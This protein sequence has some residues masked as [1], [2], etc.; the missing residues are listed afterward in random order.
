MYLAS[1]TLHVLGTIFWLGGMFFEL[2]A[3]S[4]EHLRVRTL[5]GRLG[6]LNAVW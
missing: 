1:V 6:R 4:K 3:G 2:D 5:V